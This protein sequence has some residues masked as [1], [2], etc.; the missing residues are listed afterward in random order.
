MRRI[1]LL[2]MA[3]AMTLVVAN[4]VAL[5][6]NKIGTEGPDRLV[7]TNGADNLLGMGGNQ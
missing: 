1:I 6:V 5:A 4:R 3:M 7:G 2:L